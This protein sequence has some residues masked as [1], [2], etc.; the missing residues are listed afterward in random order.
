MEEARI[1]LRLSGVSRASGGMY[2]NVVMEGVSR[3]VGDIVCEDCKWDGVTT[4]DGS[5]TA[6]TLTAKGKSDIRGDVRGEVIRLEGYMKI[7]GLCDAEKFVGMGAFT[8]E[9]LL[10]AGDISLQVYGP[11]RIHEIGAETIRV[12]RESG[13]SLFGRLKTLTAD[14]IEGDEIYL[15]YTKARAVRGNK[16]TLGA[17]CNI[18]V[19]EYRAEFEQHAKAHIG[20]QKKL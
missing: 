13:R 2:Q 9:G 16:V 10:N 8:I 3:V 14:I 1:D 4:I 7:G 19:V 12:Q 17:G 6:K 11:T 20:T 15:E 18:D 5:I